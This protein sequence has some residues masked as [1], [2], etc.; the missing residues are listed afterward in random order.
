[1]RQGAT[2][3]EMAATLKAAPGS[4]GMK[5]F[6]LTV[7]KIA[8]VALLLWWVLHNVPVLIMPLVGALVIGLALALIGS[9]AAVAGL[10]LAV[11]LVTVALTVVLALAAA[12][13]PVW[14]PV[15]AVIGLV[16]PCRPRKR[17]DAPMAS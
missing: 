12:L 3:A 1:M 17:P 10:S 2:I 13:S 4:W 8:L 5:T 6:F 15:L 14:L 9:V 11:V 7:L 16:A